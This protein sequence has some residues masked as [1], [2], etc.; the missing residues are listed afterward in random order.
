MAATCLDGPRSQQQA[1]LI[2]VTFVP[3]TNRVKCFVKL[4][5]FQDG[6]RLSK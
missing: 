5:L 1:L 6:W 2:L 4:T 3:R